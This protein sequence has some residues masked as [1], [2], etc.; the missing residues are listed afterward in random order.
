MGAKIT[1][2]NE[3]RLIELGIVISTC[4]KIKGM[5]QEGLAAEAE[6]SRSLISAIEAPR[7]AYNFTLDILLNIANALD[8]RAEELLKGDWPAALKD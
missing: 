3:K 4:R 1:E 8:A 2:K 7:L 5:T 6:I